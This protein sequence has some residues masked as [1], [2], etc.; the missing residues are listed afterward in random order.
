M[1]DIV[2]RPHQSPR[3]RRVRPTLERRAVAWL[4]DFNA[5]AALPGFNIAGHLLELANGEAH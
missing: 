5:S 3:F 1:T 4:R 2:S